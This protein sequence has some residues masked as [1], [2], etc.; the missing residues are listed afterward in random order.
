M[1]RAFVYL[2]ACGLVN[3]ARVRVRRL[4]EPR[5]LAG[6][7]VGVLYFYFVLFGRSGGSRGQVSAAGVKALAGIAGPLV[8]MASVVLF[9]ATR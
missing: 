4:R 5:Y 1:I 7:T 3:R 2:T 9:R 8:A 6:L